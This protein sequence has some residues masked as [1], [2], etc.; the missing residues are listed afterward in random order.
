MTDIRSFLRYLMPGL[1]FFVELML[2]LVSASFSETV[3]AMRSGFSDADLG[4]VFGATLVLA[5]IG[6]LLG[7]LHHSLCWSSLGVWYNVADLRPVLKRLE[8]A[9]LLRLELQGD[10]ANAISSGQLSPAGAWRV[11]TVL[12]HCR[13]ETSQRIKGAAPRAESLF[14]L[15]HGAGAALIA[16]TLASIIAIAISSYVYNHPHLW[17]ALIT[18]L[19]LL[20]I[21]WTSYRQT[22]AQAR[23]VVELVL[24]DEMASVATTQ[25]SSPLSGTNNPLTAAVGP[26]SPVFRVS[27]D[28]LQVG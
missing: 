5:G 4:D 25:A 14:D 19:I 16:S 12:W 22:G 9:G 18:C 21:H 11:F 13:R 3:V 17:V 26:I 1:T 20:L 10:G 6:Y 23:G 24:F 28:E 15:M 7:V 8:A 27:R 2:I